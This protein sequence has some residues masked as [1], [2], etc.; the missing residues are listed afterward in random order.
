MK[1]K[2]LLLVDYTKIVISY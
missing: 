1:H 2:R